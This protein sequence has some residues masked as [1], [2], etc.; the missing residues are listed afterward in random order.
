MSV[1]LV[2]LGSVVSVYINE[3]LV[4][5][6]TMA[7]TSKSNGTTNSMAI[8]CNNVYKTVEHVHTAVLAFIDK[9]NIGV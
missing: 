9:W 5:Q 2:N 6:F 4:S 3:R 1:N 7:D 8:Y